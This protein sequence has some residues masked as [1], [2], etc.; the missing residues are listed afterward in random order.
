MRRLC[1]RPG[2]GAPA[3][4][5]YGID[6]VQ[7]VVWIDNRAIFE[8]ELAGR[9]CRRHADALVVPRGWTVDDRREPIPKLFVVPDAPSSAERV[10]PDGAA[11]NARV[12]KETRERSGRDRSHDVG[13]FESAARMETDSSES[14]SA[15]TS[16]ATSESEVISSDAVAE[17]ARTTSGEEETKAIPWSPRLMRTEDDEESPAPVMGRLLGRAFGRDRDR[18]S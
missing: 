6:S 12:A 10:N 14:S 3:E 1:E 7:L 17:S 16:P 5:S 13:L 11:S 15:P 18:S 9:L 4:A 8:R 2:C